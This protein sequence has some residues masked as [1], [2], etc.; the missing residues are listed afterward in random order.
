MK[1]FDNMNF[2]INLGSWNSIFAVPSDVVDKHIKLAGA[3]QLKVLLYI[4]RHS[5][6]S[7]SSES[8]AEA[9]SMQPA[10]VNDAIQYWIETEVL[11]KTEDGFS[12][13]PATKVTVSQRSEPYLTNVSANKK[14]EV[15]VI[16]KSPSSPCLPYSSFQREQKNIRPSRVPSRPEIADSLFVT[17]RIEE[18]ASISYLIQEA[19]LI[20]GKT[21]SPGDCAKIL[22]LHD[23]DG[24]PIDVILML[25]QYA[26]SINKNY[27][28]YIEKLAIS[29]SDEG[30]DSLEKAEAKILSLTKARRAYRIVQK[31]TG[32]EYH[33]PTAL[34]IEF[35][36]TWIYKW[37]FSEVLIRHAY[38]RC[39]N[40]TGKFSFN[41][42]NRILENWFQKHITTI[43]QAVEEQ[44]ATKQQNAAKYQG[45]TYDIDAYEE[46]NI[47]DE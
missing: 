10:D 23:T 39:V 30:I 4:L 8:V 26:V 40:R 15:P 17:K 12:P 2:S 16:C 44:N 13:S 25:L 35:C 32:I 43:R 9:L 36:T 34:E 41:Y 21:L 33:S 28:R 11:A 19:E 18:S 20:L 27:M 24:L 5:G 31:I 22:T 3:A 14:I 37:K 38:E 7:I 1:G 45:S 46:S 42:T 6:D 29:W 47:F